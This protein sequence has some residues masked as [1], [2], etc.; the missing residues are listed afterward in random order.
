LEIF[1]IAFKTTITHLRN[2]EIIRT[3]KPQTPVKL[4]IDNAQL[5]SNRDIGMNMRHS[6]IRIMSIPAYSG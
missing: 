5:S 6:P 4:S 1:L 3:T 2:K